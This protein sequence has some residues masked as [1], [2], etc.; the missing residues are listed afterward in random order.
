MG[1]DIFFMRS[2]L[3]DE[4]VEKKDPFTGKVRSVRVQEPLTEHD[5][6]AVRAVLR[7]TGMSE[8]NKFGVSLIEF[9]DGAS[10]DFDATRLEAGCRVTIRGALSPDCLQFLV[11]LLKA[12]EWVMLPVMD[13]SVAIVSSPGLASAVAAGFLEVVCGTPEELEI[14]LSG[15]FEA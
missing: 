12:A 15:G 14:I 11:N 9:E 13:G 4:M 3:R 1:F 10:V 5:V 2:G 7:R 6:D 8:P